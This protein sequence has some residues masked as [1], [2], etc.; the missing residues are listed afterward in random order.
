MR[1]PSLLRR[2]AGQ[3]AWAAGSTRPGKAFLASYLHGVQD[4]ATVS[5]VELFNKALREMKERKIVMKFLCVFL[6]LAM[7]SE[8]MGIRKV[9]TSWDSPIP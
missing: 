8:P 9:V 7:Q 6:M 3:L 4:K 1:D 2:C 5:H